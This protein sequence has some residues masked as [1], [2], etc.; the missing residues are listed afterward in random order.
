MEDAQSPATATLKATR[1]ICQSLS[2]LARAV[3]RPGFESVVTRTGALMA[4]GQLLNFTNDIRIN[5]HD[6]LACFAHV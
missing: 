1:A 5:D 6:T 2:Q 4:T 3:Y